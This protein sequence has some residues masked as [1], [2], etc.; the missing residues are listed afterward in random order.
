MGERVLMMHPTNEIPCGRVP[1]FLDRSGLATNTRRFSNIGLRWAAVSFGAA[2]QVFKSN[3]AEQQSY[4]IPNTG[5]AAE[6][7][8]GL[9]LSKVSACSLT[10]LSPNA[11]GCLG[12]LRRRAA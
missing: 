4:D 11:H 5:I 9:R 6:N 3:L 7:S 10:S 2:E 8:A 12:G 1:I